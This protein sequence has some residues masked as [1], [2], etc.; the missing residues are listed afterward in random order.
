MIVDTYGGG[1][2]GLA[3]F[4]GADTQ[5]QAAKHEEKKKFMCRGVQRR[6]DWKGKRQCDTVVR[7]GVSARGG[8]G[9]GR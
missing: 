4:W 1:T 9:R 5:G 8:R 6:E 2:F 3:P 7:A